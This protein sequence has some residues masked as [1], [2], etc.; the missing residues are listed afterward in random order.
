MVCENPHCLI[1]FLAAHEINR[2]PNSKEEEKI[3]NGILIVANW[4]SLLTRMD[5]R[6]IVKI[7]LDRSGKKIYVY[8]NNRSGIEWFYSFMERNK[9]LPERLAQSIKNVE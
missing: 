5:I 4:E 2:W 7:H 1:N 3:T 6:Q 8:K 9:P